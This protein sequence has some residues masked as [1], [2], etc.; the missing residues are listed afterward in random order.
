MTIQTD[1]VRAWL[2]GTP[3]VELTVKR[4][5][6]LSLD[7]GRAPHVQGTLTIAR[8]TLATLTALDPRLGARVRVTKAITTATGTASRSFDLGI[9]SRALSQRSAVVVLELASDEALLDDW[10]PL[11]LDASCVAKAGS[12]RQVVNYVL[13]K[14]I[15]GAALAASPALDA[16]MTMLDVDNLVANP[17]VEV[18]TSGWAT[19]SA[20]S[21]SS[22]RLVAATPEGAAFY[23]CTFNAAQ[24]A[25]GYGIYAAGIPARPGTS[26]TSSIWVRSS[27]AQTVR[28][29]IEFISSTSTAV[30]SAVG[31]SVAVPADVW[32]RI[33][34]ADALAPA[35][36]ATITTTVYGDAGAVAWAN[37]DR[38]D[39]DG[40]RVGPTASEPL[41]WK[42]GVSGLEFLS[43]LVQKAGYRLVCDESRTWTLRDATYTA[44]GSVTVAYGVNLIEGDDTLSRDDETWMDA[45]ICR[46]RWTGAGGASMEAIDAYSLTGSYTSAQTIDIS[47]PYPGP[48]RAMYAVQR[49]QGRGREVTAT[50][51]TDLTANA[52]QPIEITLD[53]AP[54]QTGVAQSVRFDLA[55]D[56]ITVTAR[57]VD[58]PIGAIDRL[59]GTIDALPGT[60]DAL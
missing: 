23:R 3:D 39:A 7:Q 17:S 46:Y 60:I 55:R 27:K 38:L 57:T 1:S 12:L 25:V 51:I 53:G 42:P 59:A 21:V 36:T 37:F 5:G 34:C 49:A 35:G 19:W 45:A 41:V 58:T 16:Q 13:G 4:A 29:G 24:S 52:E 32:V 43:T 6:D 48:G 47:A 22:A 10:A 28:C 56:E 11:A 31:P 54:I 2:I 9:R 15:P 20:G 33:A 44:P 30:G 50:R 26:Y 40:L 18:D 8:P 14:V